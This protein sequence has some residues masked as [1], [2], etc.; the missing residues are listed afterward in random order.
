[1]T[2]TLIAAFEV[3]PDA[4]AAFLAAQRGHGATLHRALRADVDFR[5]VAVAPADDARPA[6]APVPF[7]T[8]AGRYEVEHEEGTPDIEGGVLRIS[9]LEVAPGEDEAFLAAWHRAREA[10]AGQR[11]YLGTRLHRAVS[12]AELRLVE[13]ARWS[14]PL[15]FA[16]AEKRSE[17]RDAT[18]AWRSHAGLYQAVAS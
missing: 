6:I 5:F 1:M 3:P 2:A 9:A 8:R 10:R 17:V 11:G 12:A 7:P 16:R 15:A 18:P 4:D 13:T 14:S